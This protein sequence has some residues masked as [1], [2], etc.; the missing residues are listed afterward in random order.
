MTCERG[1]ITGMSIAGGNSSTRSKRALVPFCPPQI[2]LDLCE[3]E[4]APP[5]W[6]AG[7]QLRELWQGLDG[8]GQQASNCRIAYGRRTWKRVVIGGSGPLRYINNGLSE[9]KS[10]Y[11]IQYD[12]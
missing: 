8:I 6:E 10:Y 4:L 3:I 5:T 7:D 9:G 12:I 2:P 11:G 1:V